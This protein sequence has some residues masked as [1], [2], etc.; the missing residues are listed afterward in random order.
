MGANLARRMLREGHEVHLLL[1]PSHQPGRVD[2]IRADVTVHEVDVEDDQGVE[3][4]FTAARPEWIFHLAAYGAYPEQRDFE[5]MLE[6]NVRG[7][8]W[9]LA[10]AE[11]T[12][13]EAFVNAGTSSEY[14][15]KDHAP[16]ES[17]VLE[18]N[19]P[20]AVTKAA[21]THLCV[22]AARRAGLPIR[23]LRLYSAYGPYEE[24]TRL[25]PT[26]VVKGLGGALPSL[27][28]PDIARDYVLVDDVCDAFE[29]AAATRE[30]EPG[31]IYNVGTGVQTTLREIVE[32]SRRLL[33]VEEEP[34][35][36]SMEQRAWDTNVWVSD[37]SLIKSCLGWEPRHD[38]A[39]GLARTVEW[40]RSHPDEVA[41]YR[42]RQSAVVRS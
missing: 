14:G 11:R 22:M 27:A 31:V 38:L 24:P 32:V 37:P 9:L 7:T 28:N 34:S 2:E 30:Q 20:Y 16:T 5:R 8:E 19:S 29:L 25:V 40:F 23:T 18:P 6:T 12:G 1:R 39:R 21:A 35:W 41:R 36:G 13:F 3:R 4:A 17:E 15:Y 10:A 26:L 33:G 42:G